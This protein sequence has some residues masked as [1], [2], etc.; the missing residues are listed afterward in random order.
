LALR[1]GTLWAQSVRCLARQWAS[2]SA[3]WLGSLWEQMSGPLLVLQMVTQRE[4]VLARPL[5]QQLKAQQTERQTEAWWERRLA[6]Q[7]ALWWVLRLVQLTAPQK[8]NASVLE[9]ERPTVPEWAS[10]LAR[11]RLAPWLAIAL[12]LRT[13]MWEY[14]WVRRFRQ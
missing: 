5:E 8:E 1:L 14:W 6:S 7:S 12:V 10:R 3:R 11:A 13:G 4:T 9:W 2:W